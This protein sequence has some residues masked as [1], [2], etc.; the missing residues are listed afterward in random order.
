MINQKSFCGKHSLFDGKF[1]Q[2]QVDG[3][4]FLLDRLTARPELVI[5]MKLRTCL[6]LFTTKQQEQCCQLKNMAEARPP[7]WL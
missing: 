6:R 3:I 7:L 5:P 1:K 2:S 4:N